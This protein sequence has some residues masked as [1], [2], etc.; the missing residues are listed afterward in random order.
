VCCHCCLDIFDPEDE[1]TLKYFSTSV[2]SRLPRVL[3]FG[4][5]FF[6]FFSS[7]KREKRKKQQGEDRE[8][9]K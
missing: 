1:V 7:K 9:G 2:L 3:S 5:E 6:R 4:R 8:R